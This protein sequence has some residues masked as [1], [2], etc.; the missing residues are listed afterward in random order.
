MPALPDVRN[1]SPSWVVSALN[2]PWAVLKYR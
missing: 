1:L 2:L